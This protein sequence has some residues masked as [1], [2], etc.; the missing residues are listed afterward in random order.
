MI[1]TGRVEIKG[2]CKSFRI[3]KD[4]KISSWPALDNINLNINPGE[5]VMI[6]GA[7]GCGKST[8]LRL[9]SGLDQ[10][11]AGSITVDRDL[12]K[13]PGAD[14]GVVFQQSTLFPWMTVWDNIIFSRRLR[15]SLNARDEQ[16]SRAVY[17]SNALVTLM[18]LDQSV[19][20]YPNQLSGGMQQR[21]NIARALVSSPKVLLMDEPFGAL[22][23]QTR[24][25]MHKVVNHL[26]KVEKTTVIFV[27]HDVE[28][29]IVLGDRIIV[30][31]ANPGRV[32]TTFTT[33]SVNRDEAGMVKKNDVSFFEFKEQILSRIRATTTMR[34]TDDLLQKVA[35]D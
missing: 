23:A 21:A 14:R 25:T 20:L 1:S 34:A 27:T 8:L 29:A 2:I 12:V 9:I 24:E 6:V 4:K 13:G 10:P 11:T 19:E 30:L 35:K 33:E 28:E 7:S 31:S 3:R 32:D 16:V 22:D 17:R 18:G 5:K 15:I 26:F